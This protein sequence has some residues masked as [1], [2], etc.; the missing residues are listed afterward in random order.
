MLITKNKNN[1]LNKKIFSQ[2]TIKK[3]IN[4]CDYHCFSF[5]QNAFAA[6]SN[7]ITFKGEV[8][9][10]TYEVTINNTNTQPVILLPTI[11][12]SELV[13]EKSSVGLTPFKLNVKGCA[14]SSDAVNVKMT[15][16]GNNVSAVRNLANMGTAANVELQLLTDSSGSSSIDMRGGA[17]V[18]GV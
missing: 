4:H 16:F 11:T 10:K 7:T 13:T 18:L 2:K 6:S 14:V 8:A 12:K 3:G 17:L 15:L 1:F 9:E 5:F